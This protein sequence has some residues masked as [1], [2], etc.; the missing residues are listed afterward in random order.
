[1]SSSYRWLCSMVKGRQVSEPSDRMEGVQSVHHKEA[2]LLAKK[3]PDTLQR[4]NV[5]LSHDNLRLLAIVHESL[6]RGREGRRYAGR[7]RIC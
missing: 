4:H 6:V 7:G 5:I 1:M 2:L 3:L